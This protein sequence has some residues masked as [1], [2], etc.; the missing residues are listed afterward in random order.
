MRILL[1]DGSSLS[2]RQIATLLSRDGHHVE[3]L[4]PGSL[5]LCRFTRHVRRVHAVPA[6]GR[7]PFG[8]L[9]AALEIAR[10]S[11]AELLFPTQD[12]VAVMSLAA[13]Q[14]AAAGLLTAVPAFAA[15]RQVQ[16][17]V[18]ATA[19]LGRAGLPQPPGR[20]ITSAAE[21]AA[22]DFLPAFVKLPVG[23]ASSGVRRVSTP[24]ELRELAA[25]Y[26]ASSVFAAGGGVL[27]QR[28]V[29]GPLVMVQSVFARGEL[30][31]A[32][33]CERVR[34][35]AHGGA[36]HKRG[37]AL[38]EVTEHIS[39]L[40]R[41][42]DWHGALSADVILGPAGPV[43]IDINP[44]LV[45][46]VNAGLSG[47]DLPGALVDIARSG[48]TAPQPPG[49]PGVRTHQLI[50]AVLAA[51]E[52]GGTR[53]AVAAEL[54]GVLTRRG[55]YRDSTEE[56]TPLRDDPA[57]LTPLALAVTAAL[58]WPPAGRRLADGGV[59]A[60]SLTPGAWRLITERAA[61]S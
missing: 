11:G 12:Q 37:R 29:A 6:Y 27:A 9:A 23:T 36:T 43:F 8:W 53:R 3:A 46:P 50:L 52:L 35:D 60:Y 22:L 49:R 15:L 48:A 10:A 56:L 58:A 39:A 44:R 26:A 31:A 40:G 41:A 18:T 7:D 5:G 14:I 16:D 34:A 20:V 13:A 4:A 51:A 32:H 54:A 30:V 33:A 25:E 59:A 38:P 61:A 24:Q 47:V 45:E 57:T 17:K 42:L 28:P 2:A 19:T 55:D 21:L 1:S